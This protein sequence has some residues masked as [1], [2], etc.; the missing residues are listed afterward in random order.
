MFFTVP[1]RGGRPELEAHKVIGFEVELS[2]SSIQRRR[3]YLDS[4][5]SFFFILNRQF[6]LSITIQVIISNK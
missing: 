3:N 4:S 2:H 6:Q 1:T 5:N